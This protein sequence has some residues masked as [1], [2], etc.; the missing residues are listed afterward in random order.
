MAVTITLDQ[1]Q[2]TAPATGATISSY[3]WD[4]GDGSSPVT[5]ASA[6][7]TKTYAVTLSQP[8]FRVQNLIAISQAEQQVLQAEAVLANAQQDL[9]L[10]VA[11]AYFD[12]LLARDNVALSE[13]QKSAISEQLAQ[14]KRNFEVGTATITDTHEAQSRYDLVVAQEIAVGSAAAKAG[15]RPGDVLLAID[16]QAVGGVEDVVATNHASQEGR[17]V[18]YTVLRM[19]TQQQ[20]ALAVQPIPSSPR[21]LYY[22]LATVGMFSLLVGASV[23]LRRPD[24]QATLHFFWLTIAFFG[25]LAGAVFGCEA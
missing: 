5:T 6:T 19:K 22:M 13:A 12:V 20:L 23:R 10:R 11:Q 1:I 25:V 8:V 17:T 4:F 9:A 2:H 16:G 14:A 21:A 24:H 3:M 15:V 7:T 18:E